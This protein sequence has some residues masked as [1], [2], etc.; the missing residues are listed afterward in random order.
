[1]GHLQVEKEQSKAKLAQQ[2]TLIHLQRS[3]EETLE[4]VE[5]APAHFVQQM[6]QTDSAG[7]KALG[8]YIGQ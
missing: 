8:L 7:T 2:H 6:T 5:L 4:Q 1:M 3:A